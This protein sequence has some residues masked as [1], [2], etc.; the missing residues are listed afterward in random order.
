[1]ALQLI[2]VTADHGHVDTLVALGEQKNA[3]DVYADERGEMDRCL[4]RYVI[5]T[6]RSQELLDALQAAIG[7]QENWRAVVLPIQASVPGPEDNARPPADEVA[8]RFSFASITVSREVIWNEVT[9]GARLDLNFLILTVL[10]TITAGIGMLTDNVAVVIGAM[11]IAPLLGPNL[12]FA[13]GTAIGDRTLMFRA[14]GTNVVGIILALFFSYVIGAFWTGAL[15]SPELLSRTVV[16]FDSIA[17][18]LA[19]GAAAVLSL[20]TG[21]SATLVGVMVAVA[22]LPP[23]AAVGIMLGSGNLA[24]A[25]SA[26]LL[27]AVNIACVNLVA[28]IVFVA[29]GIGPRT[30][31]EKKAS[32]P[33]RYINVSVWLL[34]VVVLATAIWFARETEGVAEGQGFASPA[35][36]SVD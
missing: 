2:E 33:A 36:V 1:M 34:L 18:A 13:F 16:G 30:W 31:A 32:R 4:V 22:L 14:L 28:Q 3:L 35:G 29:K 12:A 21:L 23:A 5:S 27:L 26:G 6:K 10:S 15:E 17:L 24:A 11:V 19:A 20:T 9:K 8:R 25:G 7:A